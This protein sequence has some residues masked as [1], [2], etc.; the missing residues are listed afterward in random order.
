[1]T[2]VPRPNGWVL[3][4]DDPASVVTYAPRVDPA[5]P[6]DPTQGGSR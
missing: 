4:D 6:T 2:L 3:V 5:P 1:M